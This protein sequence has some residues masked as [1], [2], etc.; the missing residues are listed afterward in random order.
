MNIEVLE[1]IGLS[2]SETKAYLAS[3]ELGSSTA[4]E[5]AD[6]AA[7]NRSNCYEALKRLIAKGLMTS[8]KRNK[9]TFFEAAQPKQLQA[10]LE[11]RENEISALI[12]ELEKHQNTAKSIQQE[13]TIFEGYEGIKAIFNESI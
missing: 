8:I 7:L 13:A 4:A 10:L 9:K 2:K 3:L 11:K 1:K 5:I 6:K 12:P